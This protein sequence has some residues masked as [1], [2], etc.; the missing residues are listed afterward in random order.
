MKNKISFDKS[1]PIDVRAV[2]LDI[3]NTF[4]KVWHKGIV[5]KLKSYGISD[6]LLKFIVNFLTDRKQKVA[7]NCQASFWYYPRMSLSIT[8]FLYIY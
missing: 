2:F 6:N 1:P 8:P 3:S 7:F 5:F 4:D